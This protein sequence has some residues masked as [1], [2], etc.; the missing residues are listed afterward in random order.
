VVDN[1][2]KKLYRYK[3]E[4]LCQQNAGIVILVPTEMVVHIALQK[5]MNIQM[6]KKNVNFAA[7]HHMEMVAL[8]ALLKN[9]DMGM[10]LTNVFGVAQHQVEMV[11]LTVQQKNTRNKALSHLV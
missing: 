6:M 11:A 3:K 10:V 8:I 9:I 2:G 7:L 5:S 4:I 1:K